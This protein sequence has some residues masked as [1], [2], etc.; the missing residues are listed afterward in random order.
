MLVI[1][2]ALGC[3]TRD[4]EQ[5]ALPT[6]DRPPPASTT[7]A[8]RRDPDVGRV[9]PEASEPLL[10][11]L[12]IAPTPEEEAAAEAMPGPLAPRAAPPR[13]CALQS[14]APMRL[15]TAGGPPSIVA[16]D[17]GAF[18]V[19]AYDQQALV[20]VRARPGALPEPIASI[21]IE[22]APPR[23]AAPGM[24]RTGP[25]EVTLAFVD[26]RGRVL[27]ATL[28][29]T[30]PASA[31]SAHELASAGADPRFPPA[32]RAVGTRR[33]IAWTDGSAT[34]MHLKLA[35]LESGRVVATHDVTPVA[36]GGAAPAFV[37]GVGDT[38]LL[39]LDPRVGISVAHR[40]VL[41]PDGAPSPTEV[42]RPL[43]LA[44]EPPA[45]AA[46]RSNVSGRTW[47]AYAAV[48]NLATRA[49]GL[50]DAAGTE[51]PSPL[52]P[53]VGY[54]DPL[55]IAAASSGRTVVF[56]AEAP[57]A[58]AREAPHEIR[59]RVVD[60]RGAGDPMVIPGPATDPALARGDDALIAVAYRG[61]GAVMV[62]FARCAE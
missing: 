20:V 23:E 1:A 33:A 17:D 46:A 43:N 27:S 47:L 57:T 41:G 22:G 52:V 2:L 58:A 15:L 32:V 6:A 8:E 60:E 12:G 40:V 30:L 49:V 25:Q 50:V 55:T 51:M 26:G 13:G 10:D 53:G 42:A 36:G 45:I 3:G 44:A 11:E 7:H 5:A 14:E 48:G 35:V 56:A 28:D 59:M 29:P 9:D 34:P 24:A 31:P 21:P 18:L 39:F 62:Q 19:A 16:L 37:D 4:D 61:G 54:G 38:M